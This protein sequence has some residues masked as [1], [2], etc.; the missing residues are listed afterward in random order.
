M[1]GVKRPS[2]SLSLV[3]KREA[4]HMRSHWYKRS[5]IPVFSHE[6]DIAPEG[7]WILSGKEDMASSNKYYFERDTVAYDQWKKQ[8]YVK[9]RVM[10]ELMKVTLNLRNFLASV[11]AQ[12]PPIISGELEHPEGSPFRKRRNVP[13]TYRPTIILDKK[14]FV[15][16]VVA[17]FKPQFEADFLVEQNLRNAIMASRGE[18]GKDNL[19]PK[20]YLANYSKEIE[21]GTFTT[22]Y[23]K[24][25]PMLIDAINWSDKLFDDDKDMLWLDVIK[26]DI[27]TGCIVVVYQACRDGI[28]PR[29]VS[30]LDEIPLTDNEKKCVRKGVSNHILRLPKPES[31]EEEEE[32][33][34]YIPSPEPVFPS[35][36]EHSDSDIKEKNLP[37][38]K[39]NKRKRQA[40]RTMTPLLLPSLRFPSPPRA[41]RSGAGRVMALDI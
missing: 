3:K 4:K 23:H 32:S 25:F 13:K 8:V 7:H 1:C 35:M 26:L 19:A 14:G 18:E 27:R 12:E 29:V 30:T 6:I 39:K 40:R 5:E 2:S 9:H 21:G 11:E 33:D 37:Q 20:V 38:K 28:S 36:P 41:R 34:A 16:M 17:D 15:N 10:R 31:E 24:A 22:A